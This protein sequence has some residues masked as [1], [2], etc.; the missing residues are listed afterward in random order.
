MIAMTIAPANISYVSHYTNNDDDNNNID[1]DDDD[2]DKLI[3][4]SLQYLT[5]VK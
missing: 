5:Q 4:S 1:N 2:D 3:N